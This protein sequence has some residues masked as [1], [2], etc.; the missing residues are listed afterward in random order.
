MFEKRTYIISEIGSNLLN[1]DL[2]KKINSAENWM[3]FL[4]FKSFDDRLFSKQ[5][6]DKSDFK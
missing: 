4:N 2:A 3:F 5:I 6:Y 1:L